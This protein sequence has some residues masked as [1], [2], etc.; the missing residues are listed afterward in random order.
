MPDNTPL[1]G[2]LTLSR[3]IY[4]SS[5]RFSGCL[6][7]FAQKVAKVKVV[8]LL[9]IRLLN[10]E[11]RHWPN[12]I[13]SSGPTLANR[14]QV[15]TLARRWLTVSV[16]WATGNYDGPATNFNVGTVGL[17]LCY[18]GYYEHTCITIIT[19]WDLRKTCKHSGILHTGILFLKR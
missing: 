18:L 10:L 19:W 16:R 13:L 3:P 4:L 17:T 15:F 6:T 9:H 1:H 5:V 11:T 2:V 7:T 14:R 8:Q 12:V